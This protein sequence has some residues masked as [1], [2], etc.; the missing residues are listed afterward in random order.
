MNRMEHEAKSER[1]VNITDDSLTVAMKSAQSLGALDEDARTVAN[2][3][4]DRR[5][6]VRAPK[7]RSGDRDMARSR[8]LTQR[9]HL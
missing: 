9:I 5:R 1:C 7:S 8:V 3:Q 4:P 2:P 6:T